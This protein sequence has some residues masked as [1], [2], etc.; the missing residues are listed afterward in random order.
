MK[1]L[2]LLF[3]VLFSIGTLNAQEQEAAV[4]LGPHH[5]GLHAG[6]STGT[7]F[8]YRYWPTRWGVQ[9]T[10]IPIFRQGSTY[11]SFGASALYMLKDNDR[12]DLFSYFG[13]HLIYNSYETLIYDPATGTYSEGKET[14][15]LDNMGLGLGLKVTIFDV[16]NLN[17]QAGYGVY[18][19]FNDPFT[20][21]TG[22][23]GLYYQL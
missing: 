20:F 13:N 7:G 6:S 12:V 10:G 2:A 15:S 5:I 4:E 8:S 16:I 11:A 9:V 23:F 22:E 19:I 17:F 18:D 21:L 1:K 14:F 3:A